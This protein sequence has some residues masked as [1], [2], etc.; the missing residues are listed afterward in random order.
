MAWVVPVVSGLVSAYSAY[1]ASQS[2]KKAAGKSSDAQVRATEM[3]IQA[4]REA[5]ERAREYYEP[6]RQIGLRAVSPMSD[7][8]YAQ[9]RGTTQQGK[10]GWKISPT[11]T[12]YR[13]G[14]ASGGGYTQ[15]SNTMGG[16]NSG[17]LGGASG[18]G[19]NRG[20]N[21]GYFGSGRNAL[22]ISRVGGSQN[23]GASRSYN[24]GISL[25]YN[26]GINP[27]ANRGIS[28]G[29]NRGINPNANRGIS[30]GYNRGIN[31]NVNKNIRSINYGGTRTSVN[32]NVIRM[33]SM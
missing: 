17:T 13:V 26:R 12:P 14:G 20:I 28:L 7:S 25:G 31:P 18:G 21:P 32:P 22:S 9:L 5:E 16:M 4:Q 30:I 19:Y 15:G 3:A 2:Q 33:L 8:V 24:R 6:F 1:Q 11:G 23:Q 10:N 29:P 27:N